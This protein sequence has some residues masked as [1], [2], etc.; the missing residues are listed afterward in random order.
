M[1]AFGVDT[2]LYTD[3]YN[4]VLNANRRWLDFFPNMGSPS[5]GT[6][7]SRI[8]TAVSLQTPADGTMLA[9]NAARTSVA[10]TAF[11]GA[12]TISLLAYELDQFTRD[13]GALPA[14]VKAFANAS[15]LAAEEIVIADL[16]AGTGGNEETLPVGQVD[17]ATDGTVTERHTTLSAL[18]V[19]IAFIRAATQSKPQ[20]LF[21]LM[22]SVCYGNFLTLINATADATAS[23]TQYGEPV[24][25]YRGIPVF[26]TAVTTNFGAAA[27][28]AAYVV[29][30]DAETINWQPFEMQPGFHKAD[31]GLWK[32]I[33]ST[34]GHAGLIQASHYATVIN[35]AS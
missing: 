20:D 9:N 34:Y 22:P 33:M 35:P 28:D 23:I 19:S 7:N 6:T 26:V 32:L 31:D 17:F 15:V 24:P 16:V 11:D 27:K 14:E 12:H 2:G 3:L 30:K 4:A 8:T 1:A 5:A 10:L 13:P 18:D 25:T 21:I 29:H